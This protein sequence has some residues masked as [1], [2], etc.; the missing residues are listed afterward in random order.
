M[1]VKDTAFLVDDLLE[2]ATVF[3]FINMRKNYQLALE[4][5]AAK[6][7]YISVE[8]MLKMLEKPT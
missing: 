4:V 1:K 8:K 6:L 7:D 2:E 3:M 5:L